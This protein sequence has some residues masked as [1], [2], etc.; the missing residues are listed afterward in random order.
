MTII[1][2]ALIILFYFLGGRSGFLG[3]ASG[4]LAEVELLL[5][6]LATSCW[7]G[8]GGHCTGSFEPEGT[9]LGAE[10]EEKRE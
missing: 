3:G 1:I 2:I 9:G 8:G 7:G 4:F 10:E 6:G 5:A